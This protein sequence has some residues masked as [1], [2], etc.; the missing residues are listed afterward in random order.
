MIAPFLELL[1]SYQGKATKCPL[2]AIDAPS[3]ENCS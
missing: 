3:N 1:A 2:A